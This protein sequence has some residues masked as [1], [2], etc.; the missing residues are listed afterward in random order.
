MTNILFIAAAGSVGAVLRY[1][2]H[3]WVSSLSTGPF[4]LGTLVGNLT[5]CIAIGFLAA[6]FTD[7]SSL[8][9]ELRLGLFVGLLG[10]FTTFSTYGLETLA[11]IENGEV[12]LA[13]LNFVLSNCLGVAGAFAGFRLASA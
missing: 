1:L 13:A 10:G 11:L 9:P 6:H 5:G 4:P 3:S 2:T 12:G 7:T 8:R